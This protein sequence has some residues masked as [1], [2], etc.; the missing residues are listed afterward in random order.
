MLSSV[1]LFQ[2]FSKN[3]VCAEFSCLIFSGELV[4]KIV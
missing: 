3:V 2:L 4:K 1:K